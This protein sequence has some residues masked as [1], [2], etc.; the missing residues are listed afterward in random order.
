MSVASSRRISLYNL[1]V[2]DGETLAL[3]LRGVSFVPSLS[4]IVVTDSAATANWKGSNTKIPGADDWADPATNASISAG[5]TVKDYEESPVGW[6]RLQSTS[7]D[8][9]L[10]VAFV[11]DLVPHY[12]D[13]DIVA[14]NT[15]ADFNLPVGDDRGFNSVQLFKYSKGSLLITAS[16]DDTAKATVSV[17]SNGVLTVTAV[18][19]G[20]ATISY[21]ARVVHGGTASGTFDVTVT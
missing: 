1:T 14:A 10:S 11:G 20:T 2:A 21:S 5:S 7:G 9:D 18:A 8:T 12:S 3:D 16:S 17:A 15:I 6:L 4:W 19:A 13:T